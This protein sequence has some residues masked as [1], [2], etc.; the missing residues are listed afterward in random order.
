[1]RERFGRPWRHGK[2]LILPVGER[3]GEVLVHFGMTGSLDWCRAGSDR[4]RHDRLEFEMR[5][6]VLRYR[7]MRKL[8]GVNRR[9]HHGPAPAVSARAHPRCGGLRQLSQPGVAVAG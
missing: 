4:H 6:G 9:P 2:W 5:G 1:L 7:D 8:T 3:D